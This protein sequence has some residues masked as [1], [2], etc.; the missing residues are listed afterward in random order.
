M[1]RHEAEDDE[2][3]V[4][5]LEREISQLAQQESGQLLAVRSWL[6]CREQVCDLR[7][8]AAQ[9]KSTFYLLGWVPEQDLPALAE[10]FREFPDLSVVTDDPGEE[11]PAKPPTKLKNG[12]LARIF[13]PFL[14]MYGLPGY[15]EIDPSLF[16]AIT[17]CLFFGIRFGKWGKESGCLSSVWPWPGSRKCGWGRSSPAAVWRPRY[18]VLYMARYSALRISSPASRF[19][20]GITWCCCWWP[21]WPWAW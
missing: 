3:K 9:S 18:S 10:R 12:V 21:L 20:R 19:W 15:D 14:K 16:M 17:Y 5:N 8:Y 1:L 13:E 7:R 6:R 4:G 2:K 11:L